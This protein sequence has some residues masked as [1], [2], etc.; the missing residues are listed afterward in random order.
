MPQLFGGHAQVVP[1]GLERGLDCRRAFIV[2]VVQDGLHHEVEILKIDDHWFV[3][4][5]TEH[6][7]HFLW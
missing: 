5:E 6:K 7:D 2:R 3:E 4:A 1:G